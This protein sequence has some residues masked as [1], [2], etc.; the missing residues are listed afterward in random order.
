MSQTKL[1]FVCLTLQKQQCSLQS[2]QQ[3]SCPCEG[4]KSKMSN[5]NKVKHIHVFPQEAQHER[6]DI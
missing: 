5:N 4:K 6:L 3:E 1:A 2:A